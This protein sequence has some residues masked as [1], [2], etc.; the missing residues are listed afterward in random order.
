LYTLYIANLL[1]RLSTR[2]SD[3]GVN[4]HLKK[5]AKESWMSH[6]QMMRMRILPCH[7]RRPVIQIIQRL[8]N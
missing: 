6:Y 8:I 1:A 7:N 4:E 3:P 5:P 2:A